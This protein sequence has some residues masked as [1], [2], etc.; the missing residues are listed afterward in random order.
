[1]PRKRR[2]LLLIPA[3]DI[4]GG[5]AVRLVQGDYDR[6]TVFDADPVAAARRWVDGGADALHVVDLDGAK[7]GA[8]HNVDA[9]RRICAAVDVPVQFGGG[10]RTAGSIAAAFE[11]SAK[12]VVLGT[13]AITDPALLEAAVAERPGAIVASVDARAGRV[14]VEAWSREAEIGPAELLRDLASRG[15]VRFLFTPVEVDGTLEGPALEALQ[16]VAR[17]A[18]AVNAKL[19]YSGGVGEVQHLRELAALGLPALEGVVVGRALYEGRFAIPAAK[20]A[21]E[22]R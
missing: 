17:A 2:V 22:G 15:V 16:P 6:E 13:A 10:L 1:V 8:P 12:R 7:S 14:A 21:L 9:L 18:E 20:V 3:I 4:R 5:R 11:A 19:L